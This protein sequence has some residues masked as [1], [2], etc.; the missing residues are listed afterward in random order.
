MHRWQMPQAFMLM[1]DQ[2]LIKLDNYSIFVEFLNGWATICA[3][4]GFWEYSACATNDPSA[5]KSVKIE[6]IAWKA[7]AVDETY[8]LGD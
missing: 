8:A 7:E 3:S 6:I 1:F 4:G 5:R 2:I